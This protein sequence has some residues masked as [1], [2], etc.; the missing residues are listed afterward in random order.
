MAANAQITAAANVERFVDDFI[1]PPFI[2]SLGYAESF[3][4]NNVRG[5][6]SNVPQID[7][8]IT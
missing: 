6:Q 3:P 2:S 8:T 5:R 1:D 4:E 7:F